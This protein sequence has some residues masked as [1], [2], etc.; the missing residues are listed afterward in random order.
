MSV[1]DD[2][3][4][5]RRSDRSGERME[6]LDLFH[7][8]R[9][10]AARL[11]RRY[12]R[13]SDRMD[14]GQVADIALLLAARRYDPE[15]GAFERFAIVTI[16]GELK[17]HLRRTGWNVHVPRRVQEDA[18]TVQAA[19]DRLTVDLG[20]SPLLSEV[21]EATGLS[22]ER[23]SNALRARSS[24]YSAPEPDGD[25][26]DSGSESEAWAD[27]VD[28]RNAVA[29][30]DDADRELVSLVFESDMTQREVG[31]AIGLSQ[32]QV[33]RRLAR[34]LQTLHTVMAGDPEI[35]G[36]VAPA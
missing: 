15:Q 32:S 28:L 36:G 3:A 24:R 4:L 17:K 9:D 16:I 11:A 19:I 14:L 2:V 13:S 35:A 25:R 10:L 1:L 31:V 26:W 23:V 18:L 6:V 12:D 33:Q 27:H 5:R 29:S 8:H 21:S 30:L 34:I 7:A 20:R 22:S